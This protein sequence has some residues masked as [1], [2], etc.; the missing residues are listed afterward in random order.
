MAR[1]S[2][3]PPSWRALIA[4][5][6]SATGCCST[7]RRR[8]RAS[9]RAARSDPSLALLARRD[10]AL[11]SLGIDPTAPPFDRQETRRAIAMTIDRDALSGIYAGL[12]RR[13]AQV[14]PPGTVGYDESI[15]EFA[16]LDV[17]AARRLLA[18]A[19]VS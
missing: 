1:R 13:A 10:A 17:A 16:P 15:V 19:R 11:A 9:R 5:G 12:V 3:P 6:P 8:S 2:T 4:A 18:D 7:I 14:V